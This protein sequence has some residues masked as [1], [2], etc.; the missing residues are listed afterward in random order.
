MKEAPVAFKTTIE[1]VTHYWCRVCEQY[2][3]ENIFSPSSI[4]YYRRRCKNCARKYYQHIYYKTPT[5]Q[6]LAC[7]KSKLRREDPNL[8]KRWEASDVEA[9]FKVAAGKSELTGA[10]GPLCIVARNPNFPLLPIN[11]M[12]ILRKE[13]RARRHLIK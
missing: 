1:D 10:K 7:L 12:C 3:P 5:A 6:R 11:A 4:K 13:A 9:I 2:R 8:A